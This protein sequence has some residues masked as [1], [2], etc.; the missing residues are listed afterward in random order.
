MADDTFI[1]LN[2]C[3]G[4]LP[5][6]IVLKIVPHSFI[7]VQFGQIR[8]QE[9]QTKTLFD[10]FGF[11][12]FLDAL[13][14]MRRM[15][16]NNQKNHFFGTVKKTLDKINKCGSSRTTFNRHEAKL[17]LGIDC[18]DNIQ[19]KR[20]RAPVVLTTGVFPWTAHVVPA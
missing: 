1:H 8:R 7:R 5:D 6:G 13:G 20:K 14:F 18:G 17:S 15:P 16:V 9:E 2:R 19:T 3:D 10:V 11:N 12:K 4:L